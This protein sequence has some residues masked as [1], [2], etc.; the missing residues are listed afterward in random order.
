LDPLLVRQD[1]DTAG[2]STT[3]EPNLERLAGALMP[4]ADAD[5]VLLF[6][7][8][9]GVAQIRDALG[10]IAAPDLVT[11]MIGADHGLT[12]TFHGVDGFIEAWRDYTDTFQNLRNE[13]TE[14][15]EVRPGVIY[16]ETRQL[17]ATA[18]AGVEIDYPA[19]A[20]F[21]FADDRLQQAEFHLD[22]EAARRAAGMDPDRPSGG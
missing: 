4:F 2:V 11:L 12:G 14:L 16:A 22:R 3:P 17:G 21:R 6:R 7:T 8:E 5:L 20:V 19:A 15:N 13:I 10:E 1:T 9:G 18:T